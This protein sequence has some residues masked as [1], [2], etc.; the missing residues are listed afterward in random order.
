EVVGRREIERIAQRF[1]LPR[2]VDV[3]AGDA[4]AGRVGAV[5]H[6]VY[7][8]VGRGGVVD[9]DAVARRHAQLVGHVLPV[10][11]VPEARAEIAREGVVV[12][13]VGGRA[14]QVDGPAQQRRGVL[15]SI[16]GRR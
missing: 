14:G 8:A 5:A 4:G 6:D 1:R 7:R 16:V 12:G 3:L 9:R 2:G 11:L 10:R 13:R 15:A